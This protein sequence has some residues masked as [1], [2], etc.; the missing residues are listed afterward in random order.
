MMD[1][2]AGVPG[3]LKTLID[4]LTAT[5]ASNLDNIDAAVTTRAPASTALSTSTWTGTRAGYLDTIP[6]LPTGVCKNV[7]TGYASSSASGGSGEDSGYLDITITSVA[8]TKT[9]VLLH[10]T[11]VS[12]N[13]RYSGRLTSS[14]NLRISTS[15]GSGSTVAV[16]WY[17]IEFY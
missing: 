4:R 14:T 1:F 13:Y 17:V 2:L 10:T 3:R 7:Q 8:T 9:F 11:L 12:Q 15:G 16:R 5:R 6:T